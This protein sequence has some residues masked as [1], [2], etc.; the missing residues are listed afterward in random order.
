MHFMPSTPTPTHAGTKRLIGM[1]E[2]RAFR[3][4][5]H[6]LFE[7]FLNR[8]AP[9]QFELRTTRDKSCLNHLMLYPKL[10]YLAG[11]S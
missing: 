3:K 1:R 11:L 2:G 9:N 4:E 6:D 10:Q 5:K 8:L 7:L